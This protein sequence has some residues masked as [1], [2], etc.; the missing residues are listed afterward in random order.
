ML[1]QEKTADKAQAKAEKSGAKVVSFDLNE[2]IVGT[3]YV[4][5]SSYTVPQASKSASGRSGSTTD[6]P[7]GG[8]ATAPISMAPGVTAGADGNDAEQMAA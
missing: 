5:T 1:Q 4:A 2:G 6:G 7:L 3:T 8:A